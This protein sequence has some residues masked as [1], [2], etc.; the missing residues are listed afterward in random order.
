[1]AC[2]SARRSIAVAL[3]PICTVASCSIPRRWWLRWSTRSG[4]FA[5]SSAAFCISAH[6]PRQRSTSPL[7]FWSSS[8]VFAHILPD[9]LPALRHP[10]RLAPGQ[11][12][13]VPGLDDAIVAVESLELRLDPGHVLRLGCQRL[14]LSARRCRAAAQFLD[15]G[16]DLDLAQLDLSKIGRAS[17]RERVCRYV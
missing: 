12:L 7:V 3:G 10:G 14:C 1:M 4:T 15:L 2:R 8:R 9:R 11:Q 16:V 5:R 6:R 17:C 13:V